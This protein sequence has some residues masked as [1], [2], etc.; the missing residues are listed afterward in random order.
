MKPI[1][2]ESPTAT[3]FGKFVFRVYKDAWGRQTVVLRTPKIDRK[4][5][6]LVRV[7]S[8]CMTGDVFA[9]LR[10]DCGPQLHK[11]L[12]LIAK[13]GN[14]ALV[15]LRQEGR[16][17]GLFEKI[18]AYKLQDEGYDTFEANIRLGHRPDERTY[19]MAKQALKDL[20]IK[21][22]KLLT[23]SPL[24]VAEMEKLGIEVV[25]RIPLIIPPNKFNKGYLA[26]KR[27]RYKLK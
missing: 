4:K 16:G 17:I 19:G 24:K 5:P 3:K 15:Y 23:N 14:G 20:G 10:C 8:E 2:V 18:K 9:S 26:I 1:F 13:G 22:I 27:D 25:E 12:K 11:A 6:A 7:H 21:R